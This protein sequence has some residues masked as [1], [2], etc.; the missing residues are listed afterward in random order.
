MKYNEESAQ[1]PSQ[2]KSL[3]FIAPMQPDVRGQG[4][5]GRLGTLQTPDFATDGEEINRN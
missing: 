3:W 5:L 2:Q 4:F 1:L